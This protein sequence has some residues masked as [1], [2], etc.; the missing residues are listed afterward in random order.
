MYQHILLA[1]ALSE[2][3]FLVE[4]KAAA[5]QKLSG[6]KL[7]IIHII[8]PMPA[9][10]AVGEVG[11]PL[12][13]YQTEQSLVDGAKKLLLP[14]LKRLNIP[15]SAMVIGTGRISY[16][17]LLYAKEKQVDLIVCGSHGRHGLQLLLGSTANSI[18]HGA[19]C[20]VLSVR[21]E[22]E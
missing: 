10:A 9:I 11:M 16:E 13:Y 2:K 12:D 1:T 6:A 18:L 8:E 21:L 17:I 20:D 5:L 19:K 7:T 22:D 3:S 4:D 14:I 15:E